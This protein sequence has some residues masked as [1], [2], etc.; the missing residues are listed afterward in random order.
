MAAAMVPGGDEDALTIT[1][2]NRAAR[3]AQLTFTC[4][5]HD[6]NS[7]S[8]VHEGNT[9]WANYFK[10]ALQGLLPHLPAEALAKGTGR[11]WVL[12][13]GT[14]PPESS[15]SSS[16]AMTTCSS[17]VVLTALGAR[18]A[19]TRK[20]MAEVAIES[21]RLVGVNSGGMDQSVS[22]FGVPGHAIYVSFV[23]SLATTPT[24]LPGGDQAP[25]AFVVSNTLVTSDKKVQ[26]PV[27]YNLRVVE[28]QMAAAVL[29][30]ALGVDADRACMPKPYRN[31]LRAVADAYW[32]TYP[33]AWHTLLQ[34]NDVREVFAAYGEEAG[35]LQAMLHLVDTHL[36]TGG[37]T[38]QEVQ[39]AVRLASPAFHD[40]FLATYPVRA[41][42]FYLHAR[43][44]HVYAE[45]RRVLQFR[46]ACNQA[47][48]HANATADETHAVYTQLGA[49]MN[50][51]HDS[52]AALYDCSC[53]ELNAVVDIARK[54][55]SLGSRLT[56]AGWGGCAVHLVP[57]KH[58]AAMTEAL[59]RLYYQPT[60]PSLGTE[61]LQ[62]ALF[63]TEPAQGAC[64]YQ[65]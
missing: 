47:K 27:Q 8:L 20:E 4:S 11:L 54:H 49:W 14:V 12:V 55:G 17:I 51:S 62:Q 40:R 38:Q 2:Q 53:P 29:A 37:M 22:I 5:V 64:V 50:E 31:T 1:L 34:N 57:R 56:G 21:E 58:V 46:A 59:A 26:G 65:P 6:P 36:P 48:E 23:P 24:P 44:T 43:A 10:V 16:A 52:L 19:I 3:F 30:H 25:Y 18:H 61:A 15:L 60:F 35:R 39:D 45:A 32:D 33:D 28:T 13:D 7:I 63:A 42:V 41:D 9:R